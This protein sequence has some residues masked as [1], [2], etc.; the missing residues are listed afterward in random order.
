MKPHRHTLTSVHLSPQFLLRL[1]P[2]AS[3]LTNTSC[4]EIL[5]GVLTVCSGSKTFFLPSVFPFEPLPKAPPYKM[6]VLIPNVCSSFRTKMMLYKIFPAPSNPC[7]NFNRQKIQVPP[8]VTSKFTVDLYPVSDESG[9]SFLSMS[10]IVSKYNLKQK[11]S[12]S[13][14]QR[15]PHGYENTVRKPYTKQPQALSSRIKQC[16][17]RSVHLALSTLAA[18]QSHTVR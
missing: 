5:T 2:Q 1:S 15:F 8:C 3:I 10:V 11:T 18:L 9:D 17:Q 14:F 13:C 7:P 12:F 6:Q 16:A 4:P